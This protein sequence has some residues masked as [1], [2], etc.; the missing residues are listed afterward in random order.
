MKKI[1]DDIKRMCPMQPYISGCTQDVDGS[2]GEAHRE[3]VAAES[4]ACK[5]ALLN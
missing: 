1:S 2:V 3:L 5:P 4:I